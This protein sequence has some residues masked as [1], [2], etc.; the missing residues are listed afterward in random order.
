MVDS[1]ALPVPGRTY[2]ALVGLSAY[3]TSLSGLPCLAGPANDVQAM[4]EWISKATDVSLLRLVTPAPLGNESVRPLRPESQEILNQLRSHIVQDAT[5]FKSE[6]LILY[7]AGHALTTYSVE[8]AVAIC[9]PEARTTNS[10][11]Y[12]FHGG[13]VDAHAIATFFR[14]TGWFRNVVLLVDGCRRVGYYNSGTGE[15]WYIDA[16]RTQELVS[17]TG[18][19]GYEQKDVRLF[20]GLACQPGQLAYERWFY[21]HQA[22]KHEKRGVFTYF[23]LKGLARLGRANGQLTAARLASYVT[24]SV[25][26]YYGSTNP[27]PDFELRYQADQL[28]LAPAEPAGSHDTVDAFFTIKP[29]AARSMRQ[30]EPAKR[31]YLGRGSWAL[32]VYKQPEIDAGPVCVP[33]PCENGKVELDRVGPLDIL[34]NACYKVELRHQL[35][36][37]QAWESIGSPVYFRVDPDP[38]PLK[39]AVEIADVNRLITALPSSTS[40]TDGGP[41]DQPERITVV[42]ALAETVYIDVTIQ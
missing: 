4:S 39:N 33:L 14:A 38:R 28:L 11:P 3:D 9:G 7:F 15:Q 20:I 22:G 19:K 2:A 34:M 36:P 37:G 25:R 17:R 18:R 6:C 16:V 5:S 24:L 8:F 32:W 1:V 23:L 13:T 29:L 27:A 26:E 10:L 12:H 35:T 41:P 21:D 40:A 30:Q 42:R 31:R